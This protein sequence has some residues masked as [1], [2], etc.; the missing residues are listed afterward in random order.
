MAEHGSIKAVVFDAYGTIFDVHSVIALAER[1]YPGAGARLSQTWRAKQIEYMFLRSLMGRYIPHDQNTESALVYA[2][3]SLGLSCSVEQ[4]KQ[5]MDAY[6]RLSPFPDT[7]EALAALSQYKRAILS[8]GTE[9]M[10]EETTT[11]AGIR[12]SFDALLSVDD[13]KIYKPHPK[14]YQLA[15]DRLNVAKTEVA[16]VTSNYFDVAG[17]KSFGFNVF[18]INRTGALPDELDLLPDVVLSRLTELRQ[19]IRDLSRSSAA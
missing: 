12:D 13:V 5:L 19:A 8:V 2:V 16:F 11:N 3:K 18:W 6:L 9:R 1:L 17:A 7:R 4:P 15:L 10:L 14:T